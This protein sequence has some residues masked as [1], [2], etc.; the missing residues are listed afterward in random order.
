M[1][2]L[3]RARESL[4][5]PD[6]LRA[7]VSE[8]DVVVHLAGRNRANEAE[9]NASNVAC[10]VGLLEAIET[11]G[12]K[13]VLLLFASSLQVYDQTPSVAQIGEDAR[14]NTTNPFS[15]SKLLAE[16]AIRKWAASGAIRA[17]SLRIANAYG[18]GCRPYYNSVIATFIDLAKNGKALPVSG[19]LQCRDFIY[20]TDVTE[21][22]E[23]LLRNQRPGYQVFNVC[24]GQATSILELAKKMS[25]FFPEIAVEIDGKPSLQGGHLVGNPMKLELETGFRPNVSLEQGLELSLRDS[26]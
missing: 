3:E 17:I 12:A 14:T 19:G 25:R 15:S 6:T 1:R 26:G 24:T 18:P 2:L 10:T 20:I 16:S 13:G 8:A 21:A 7:F 5:R 9:L 22:M 4:D 23:I 11:F